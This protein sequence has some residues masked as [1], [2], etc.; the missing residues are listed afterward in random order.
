M[1]L[2]E[3]RERFKFVSDVAK[4]IKIPGYRV[5]VTGFFSASPNF[6]TFSPPGELPGRP[7]HP[8]G[9]VVLYLEYDEKD[10]ETGK[11][12]LQR[13]RPWMIDAGATEMAIIQTSFK[14][15]L[16]SLEHRARENFTYM[17]V[18]VLHPHHTLRDLM[19]CAQTRNVE[20]DPVKFGT[21]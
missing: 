13:T 15:Y 6:Q 14:A 18:A 17:N 10:V 5:T 1:D 19:E 16:T 12:E 3:Y 8:D 11:V 21:E 20:A 4:Q 7:H 2:K 9:F